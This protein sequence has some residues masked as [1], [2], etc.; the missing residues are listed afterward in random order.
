[1]EP[2]YYTSRGQQIEALNAQKT[3]IAKDLERL[4]FKRP[5]QRTHTSGILQLPKEVIYKILL[6][7]FKEKLL[8]N[9]RGW[10]QPLLK[11]EEIDIIK[12][13]C[14]N[15]N[16]IAIEILKDICKKNPS[17]IELLDW[18]E[19]SKNP[20]AIEI[21][22]LEENRKHIKWYELAGNSAAYDLLLEEKETNP[23]NFH[24]GNFSANSKGYSL[25]ADRAF[26]EASMGVDEYDELHEPEKLDWAKVSSNRSSKVLNY[27]KEFHP[28]KINYG[29]LSGNPNPIA[30]EMLRVKIEEEKRL[31]PR[32]LDARHYKDKIDWFL[33]SGNYAAINLLKENR[34]KI[35]YDYLGANEKAISLIRERIRKEKQ[36]RVN[37]KLLEDARKQRVAKLKEKGKT[38]TE[39]DA[40]VPRTKNFLYGSNILNWVLINTNRKAINI[41]KENQDKIHLDNLLKN[42]SIFESDRGNMQLFNSKTSPIKWNTSS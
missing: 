28:D 37:A 39:A 24:W 12:N 19:L 35:R 41:L 1:M 26:V 5:L 22:Q 8:F 4:V 9:F 40:L 14:A 11:L 10:I 6:E 31:R 36:L 34:D 42:P 7:Q 29:S 33:L 23:V 20:I 21:L 15:T 18:K 17:V 25:I 3:K 30:I 13:L 2:P 27:L 32:R 16:V 38:S